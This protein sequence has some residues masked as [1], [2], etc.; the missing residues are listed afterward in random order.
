MCT[1]SN[2]FKLYKNNKIHCTIEGLISCDFIEKD[3]NGRQI[4]QSKLYSTN[5]TFDKNII[6]LI[7]NI[8]QSTSNIYPSPS[9]LLNFWHLDVFLLHKDV[10]KKGSKIKAEG[11]IGFKVYERT[12]GEKRL[13]L[14]FA[15]NNI[16]NVQALNTT[17][18]NSSPSPQLN[19]KDSCS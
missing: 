6:K 7:N 19:P 2:N 14:F 13:H 11:V 12:Y 10:L 9:I 8:D 4:F 15:V 18:I 3:I 16:I 5:S 17:F 1:Y